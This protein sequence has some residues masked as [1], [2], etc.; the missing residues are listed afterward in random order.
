MLLDLKTT[1]NQDPFLSQMAC[2]MGRGVG[3][4]RISKGF[5]SCGHWNFEWH[6][7]DEKSWEKCADLTGVK[8]PDG[9]DLHCYGV[10]DSPAQLSEM[11][12]AQLDKLADEFV[13][14]LVRLRRSE[15]PPEGGWRWHKWGPYI[16]T[17][18]PQHEYLAH[19]PEIEEV[20]TYHV[21]QRR[22][23]P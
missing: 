1:D 12:A 20:W 3:V 10:C 18:H 22:A 9:D 23:V 19:E 5:Y 2:L 6:L 14:A 8:L 17:R 4:E 21:Y 16:G 13:V 7:P 15:E 11:V